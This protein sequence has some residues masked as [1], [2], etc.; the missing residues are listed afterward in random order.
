M[1]YIQD[2]QHIFVMH[3]RDRKNLDPTQALFPLHNWD[4]N[5]S[6]SELPQ[7]SVPFASL[8][9]ASNLGEFLPLDQ[10]TEHV[11]LPLLS[12]RF[13]SVWTW[14]YVSIRWLTNMSLCSTCGTRP[15]GSPLASTAQSPRFSRT[16]WTVGTC[17]CV[18]TG[19]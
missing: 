5:F 11:A 6:F 7:F 8:A 12:G 19:D 3:F 17:L 14:R 13:E 10:R 4:V 15:V 1:F 2:V 16:F 9:P 18:I